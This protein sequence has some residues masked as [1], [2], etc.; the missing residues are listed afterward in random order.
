VAQDVGPKFKSQYQKKKKKK[1][2]S[3]RIFKWTFPLPDTKGMTQE[4]NR[5]PEN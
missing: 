3:N 5:Q 1:E 2:Y 4:P